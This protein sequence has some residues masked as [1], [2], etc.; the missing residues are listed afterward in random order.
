MLAHNVPWLCEVTS[1]GTDYFLS[2]L[3]F[4]A[5]CKSEFITKFAIARNGC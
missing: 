4:L 5:K 2:K 1:L 3:K